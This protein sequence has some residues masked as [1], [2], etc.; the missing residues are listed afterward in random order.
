MKLITIVK[1][2]DIIRL[3]ISGINKEEASVVLLQYIKVQKSNSIQTDI[4]KSQNFFSF[5]LYHTQIILIQA[6]NHIIIFMISHK[7]IHIVV[8]IR[9]HIQLVKRITH[10][11]GIIFSIIKFERLFLSSSIKF[12][13]F[14]F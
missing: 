14:I 1:I 13:S 7:F 8:Y 11:I 12:K 4:I 10:I 5:N 6:I 9:Y 2:K 3:R